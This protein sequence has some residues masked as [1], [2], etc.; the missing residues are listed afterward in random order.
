MI[1]LQRS[2]RRHKYCIGV[3]K[4]SSWFSKQVPYLPNDCTC[5]YS[6]FS[7][8]R[9]A[10]R[11]NRGGILR[12]AAENVRITSVNIEIWHFHLESFYFRRGQGKPRG[13]SGVA[14]GLVMPLQ[15]LLTVQVAEEEGEEIGE[16][17]QTNISKTNIMF[18]S[19]DEQL[20]GSLI[21]QDPDVVCDRLL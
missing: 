14:R 11:A 21:F 7:T 17:K 20:S 13:R 2:T 4:D 9:W 15:F 19:W 8:Y 16:G 1:V 3:S 10:Q 5:Y 18:R 12:E 6:S